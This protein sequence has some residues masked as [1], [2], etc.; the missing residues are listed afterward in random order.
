MRRSNMSVIDEIKELE[1]QKQK[2]LNEA[3]TV[4]IKVYGKH[5]HAWRM[6]MSYTVFF[7]LFIGVQRVHPESWT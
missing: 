3:N 6:F 4:R 7:S 5:Q 1:S 2:L